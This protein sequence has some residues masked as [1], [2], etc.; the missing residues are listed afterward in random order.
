[1]IDQEP[2]KEELLEVSR[3]RARST[4]I[5]EASPRSSPPRPGRIVGRSL[6]TTVC[7]GLA[8]AILTATPSTA[9][10]TSTAEHVTINRVV[11]PLVG[12][13]IVLARFNR[14]NKP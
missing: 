2:D 11:E 1:M 4:V 6:P 3:V 9:P 10:R 7:L 13:A 12:D 5:A 14:L 8:A